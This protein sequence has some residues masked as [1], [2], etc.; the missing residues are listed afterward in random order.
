MSGGPPPRVKSPFKV[1][2]WTS[3]DAYTIKEIKDRWMVNR[4][5]AKFLRKFIKNPTPKE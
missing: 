1:I 3:T 5:H 2:S 4:V